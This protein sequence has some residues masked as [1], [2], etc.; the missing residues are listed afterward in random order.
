[1]SRRWLF[2]HADLH[3]VLL[4]PFLVERNLIVAGH[5]QAQ[6]VADGRHPHAEI[7]GA[8]AI[9]GDVHLRIRHAEADLDLG[10]ARA[11]S[12]PPRA[13][14]SS[15]RRSG[16]DPARECS[17]RSRSRPPFAAAERVARRDAR[18]VAG[19]RRQPAAHF[20][21]HLRLRILAR[22]RSAA[23]DRGSGCASASPSLPKRRSTARSAPPLRCRSFLEQLERD[24]GESLR[25]MCLPA[26]PACTIHSPM[27]SLGTNSRPTMRFNGNVSR[28]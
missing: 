12:A 24:L 25:A 3:R 10:E 1:M 4:L 23:P 20:G 11:A 16:R 8:L 6:R 2:E 21:H 9:D 15:I 27:S 17:P 14:S 26:R 19:M 7:G 5:R 22:A 13:R 18:P 28:T